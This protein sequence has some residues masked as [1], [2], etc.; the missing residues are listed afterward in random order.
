MRGSLL[1]LPVQAMG[2]KTGT[3]ALEGTSCCVL[4]WIPYLKPQA[5]CSFLPQAQAFKTPD[6]SQ[7]A[8]NTR[9]SQERSLEMPS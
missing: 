3:L 5:L 2:K 8:L 6:N 1:T 4:K 9:T 7:E